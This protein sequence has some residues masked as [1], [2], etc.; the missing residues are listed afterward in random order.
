ML[1]LEVMIYAGTLT[2]RAAAGWH[3]RRA[4]RLSIIEF[5]ALI[6]TLGAGRFLPGRYGS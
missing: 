3:G 5:V 2:G 6:V 1:G 4:A